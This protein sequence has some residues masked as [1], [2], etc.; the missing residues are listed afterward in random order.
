MKDVK[1]YI[2]QFL[3]F[4][5]ICISSVAFLVVFKSSAGEGEDLDEDIKLDLAKEEEQK[6][7]I[8]GCQDADSSVI[9]DVSGVFD[10]ATV[11]DGNVVLGNT[12]IPDSPF[13]VEDY[14]WFSVEPYIDVM[15]ATS[16]VNIRELP[17]VNYNKIGLLSYGDSIDVDGKCSN[18]WYRV[19]YNGGYAYISGNYL[20]VKEPDTLVAP[21]YSGFI[22]RDGNIDNKWLYKLEANYV[23]VPQ[24]V[25]THFESN[26]WSVIC[27]SQHL[28]TLFYSDSS[29]SI[30]AV[31]ALD[32]KTIWVEAREAA[33]TS[34]VHELGHYIDFSF[35][36]ASSTEEFK[37][38]YEEELQ[39]FRTIVST[40][41]NN[42]STVSEYFAESY[43][44]SIEY[45]ELMSQYCP[46][47]YEYVMRYS[48]SL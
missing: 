47:T 17:S 46:K 28:G 10:S 7:G 26:G 12:A 21:E 39:L 42:T 13:V 34:I 43:A 14:G 11:S 4:L 41:E 29:L 37:G 32:K 25:R 15:Y 44:I 24:N 22:Q 2:P 38:I 1:K 27:T 48:N 35:S 33:M 3:L 5:A 30:Q 36:W 8:L 23:K 9:V 16:S 6:E 19:L 18:G 20:A 45:P 40:H 31:N